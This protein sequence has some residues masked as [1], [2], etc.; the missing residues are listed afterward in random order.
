VLT[1]FITCTP[2]PSSTD[3]ENVLI[4]NKNNNSLYQAHVAFAGGGYRAHSGH[5]GWTIGLLNKGSRSLDNAFSNVNTLSSNSGGSWFSTMLMYSVPFINQIQNANADSTWAKS[6]W[7]GHQETLY[8]NAPCHLLS[9]D[10]FT[11]CV[12]EWYASDRQHTL[13]V[14]HWYDV[15]H[16]LV[17]NKYPI[18]Q[19][20][21][22]PLSTWASKKSLLLAGSLLTSQVVLNKNYNLDNNY[23]Q[24][25]LPPHKVTTYKRQGSYCYTTGTRVL[26]IVSPVTFYRIPKGLGITP[27]AFLPEVKANT[28][29]PYLS[30]EYVSDDWHGNFPV[31][32]Q[33]IYN[34]VSTD[35]VHVIDAAAASSA[36]LGFEASKN[37]S[38]S[39][40]SSY[41]AEDLALSFQL[42]DSVKYFKP[43]DMGIKNLA[44]NK[45]VRIADGGPVDNSGVAQL[46]S[47]LQKN[48]PTRGIN[49]IAFDN[50]TSVYNNSRITVPVGIDIAN[51]FGFGTCENFGTDRFCSESGCSG[52]CLPTTSLKIFVSDSLKVNRPNWIKHKDTTHYVVY[53]KYSFKTV[54]NDSY[55]IAGGTEGTLHAF[56]CMW[57]NADTTPENKGKSKYK[58]KTTDQDFKAYSEMINFI[59]SSLHDNNSEGLNMLEKAFGL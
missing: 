54:K 6:G 28:H 19:K 23:Y 24:A 13:G 36:A 37:I 33:K 18:T 1:I 35:L 8:N 34:P 7:L 26:P 30:M 49:I 32:P 3:N 21:G 45:I 53:T 27:P 58:I 51:L 15:V 48:K 16:K 56:T 42:T 41:V 44:T 10:A 11:A 43:G 47:H 50:V 38:G 52:T 22:D 57:K 9:G 31:V 12:A 25:C 46:V 59:G 55:D 40:D 29:A 14:A 39:F 4:N 5:A 17:F 2:T 20:L